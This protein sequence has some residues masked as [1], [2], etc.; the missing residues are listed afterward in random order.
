MNL[1]ATGSLKTFGLL[2]L[3]LATINN[4][5]KTQYY[6]SFFSQVEVDR[7]PID[8]KCAFPQKYVLTSGCNLLDKECGDVR[9][10]MLSLSWLYLNIAFFKHICLL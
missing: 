2:K 3:K 10:L 8:R 1:Y 9:Q 7:K 6:C 5:F 4:K